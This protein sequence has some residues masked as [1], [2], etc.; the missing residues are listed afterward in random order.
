ITGTPAFFVV[1]PD[2]KIS[3]IQG[4]QPFSVFESTI[5]AHLG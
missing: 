2:E 5:N 4:A 1:G 3:Q